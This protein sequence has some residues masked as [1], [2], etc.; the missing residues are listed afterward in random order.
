MHNYIFIAR[1]ASTGAGVRPDVTLKLSQ[2]QNLCKRD[3]QGHRTDYDA[4]IRRLQSECHILSLSPSARPPPQLSELIQFAAAVS[5]SSYDTETSN[6]VSDLLVCLLLGKSYD[7]GEKIGGPV[8]LVETSKTS[9]SRKN[10]D[11]FKFAD[12]IMS[13]P[14]SAL[15]LHRD[16][17]KS[18]VSALILIRNK[19][20]LPPLKL[21]E[22]FFRIM[23]VIPDKGL[24]EQ[25]YKHIVNDVRNINKKG[26]R[27]DTVNKNVQ[28]FLH[29]VVASTMENKKNNN[30][31]NKADIDEATQFAAKRA[32]DM[33]A[34]LYR[35]RVWTD[36]RTVAILASG[37]ESV[38]PTVA[39]ACMRFFLGIEEK[40][41]DD[42]DKEANHQWD[43]VQRID[44][45]VHSRKTKVRNQSLGA[46]GPES[47]CTL[48]SV[49]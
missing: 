30:N 45:H 20:K 12:V 29:K 43:G 32:V 1:M 35:R 7:T 47:T 46:D 37:V 40:M 4:Q 23:A 19:G 38:V 27:D 49:V 3:P 39:A 10:I 41:A 6:M 13:L 22:L 34:E 21:L 44:Y 48:F 25:L 2:L 18:C 28:S 42:E 26:K 11:H 24:R 31:R 36:E 5:S 33:T 14:T 16:V 9:K 15:N 17:R 8:K